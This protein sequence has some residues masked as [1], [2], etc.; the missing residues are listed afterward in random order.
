MCYYSI[1][2]ICCMRFFIEIS[3]RGTNYHGW[4]VQPNANTIQ[5]EIN[6]A[7]SAILDSKISIIGAS[8]TDAG[9]HANRTYAHFDYP[10]IFDCKEIVLRLNGFL[11]KDIVVHNIFEVD[12][13]INSRFDAISR[14]YN[15]HIIQYKNAFKRDAYFFHKSLNI[16]EMNIACQHL[17]GEHDFTS[18]SK[19]H[20]QTK[21]NICTVTY[22]NWTQ[23][24]EQIIFTITANRFLRNM[25]RAIVGTMLDIGMGKLSNQDM[26]DIFLKKDR[27]SAGFSVP[28]CGLFLDDI[29]YPNSIFDDK[30]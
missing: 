5:H 6:K 20:T 9:V 27:S 11:P 25:V 3:Y 23:D 28:A 18:F 15:Y 29:D 26:Q 30:K 2:Y 8:R 14:T 16:D 1:N 17:I 4:Q 22:A 24:Q 19:S 12:Q 7:L 13:Q 21:T 10:L